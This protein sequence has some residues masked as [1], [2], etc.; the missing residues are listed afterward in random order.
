MTP[1]E[2][3]TL[4]ESRAILLRAA[5]VTEVSVEGCTAKF[6]PFV[7][8]REVQFPGMDDASE[9]GAVSIEE[10]LNALDDPMTFGGVL[11]GYKLPEQ[12]V[13]HPSPVEVE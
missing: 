11:P 13:T 7:P 3:L 9:P 8:P 12:P 10:H 4:L 5:G 2:W 1:A 6:A